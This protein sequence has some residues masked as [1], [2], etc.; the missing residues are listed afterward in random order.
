MS[1]WVKQAQDFN[2]GDRY[3]RLVI[4][5]VY[6]SEVTSGTGHRVSYLGNVCMFVREVTEVL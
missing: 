6:N 5:T 4:L 1:G 3:Q 2:S